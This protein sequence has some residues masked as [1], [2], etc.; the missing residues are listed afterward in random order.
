MSATE[1]KLLQGVID[2]A[3]SRIQFKVKHLMI[4]NVLGSFKEFEGKASMIENDF[5]STSVTFTLKTAS[6]DTEAPDR[7]AHLKSADFFDA[8]KYP[9][10]EFEGKG[11]VQKDEENYELTGNLTIKGISKPVTLAVEFGGF[12]TDPWGNKKAGFSVTGEIKRK[13]WGMEWNAALETGGVLVG[14]KVKILCDVEFA[15][16]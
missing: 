5:S 4:S 14:D 3:H 16:S 1:S 12:M 13:D 2:P 9:T 8:E 11:M 6:I 7:D 10:I 15:I